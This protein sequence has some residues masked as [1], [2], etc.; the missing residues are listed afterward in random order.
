MV[1]TCIECMV[2][3]LIDSHSGS[4]GGTQRNSSFGPH[5]EVRLSQQMAKNSI[6]PWKLC[7]TVLCI[8][9]ITLVA[10]SHVIHKQEGVLSSITWAHTMPRLVIVVLWLFSIALYWVNVLGL[11]QLPQVSQNKMIKQVQFRPIHGIK[12]KKRC[13]TGSLF[14][15][16]VTA[17][18]IIIGN[19]RVIHL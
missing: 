14:S 12:I 10:T 17:H 9:I 13:T 7:S 4:Q 16:W 2:S 1:E 6:S 5:L 3:Y 8:Q 19:L 11:A 15:K 18:S